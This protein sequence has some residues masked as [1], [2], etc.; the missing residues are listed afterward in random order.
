MLC[1]VRMERG[2]VV[3]ETAR[4]VCT[5]F[6]IQFLFDCLPLPPSLPLVIC[7]PYSQNLTA[8]VQATV[9]A[10]GGNRAGTIVSFDCSTGYH[11]VGSGRITCLD[12]GRWDGS[13]P[14]CVSGEPG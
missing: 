5:K 10:S 12:N 3:W 13:V 8:H 2:A 9:T 1:V 4:K 14:T 6:V 11:I 7:P